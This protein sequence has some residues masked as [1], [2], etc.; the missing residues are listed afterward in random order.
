VIAA[1]EDTEPSLRDH[2]ADVCV[3][4]QD[5]DAHHLYVKP[6][7]I[8]QTLGDRTAIRLSSISADQP[9]EIRAQAAD[10][11]ARNLKEA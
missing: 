2:W 9:T 11:A 3:A 6:D 5:D 10:F 4:F 7:R 1:D 8:L